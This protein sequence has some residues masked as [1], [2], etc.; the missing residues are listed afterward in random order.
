MEVSRQ[1]PDSDVG[2][3]LQCPDPQA[4]ISRFAY[5]PVGQWPTGGFLADVLKLR[6]AT[7]PAMGEFSRS[8]CRKHICLK[9]LVTNRWPEAALRSSSMAFRSGSPRNAAPCQGSAPTW[10]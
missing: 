8:G 1:E 4:S 3:A 2:F 6:S 7:K 9:T 10:K 5:M